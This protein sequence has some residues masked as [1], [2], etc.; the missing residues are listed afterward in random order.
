MPSPQTCRV[1]HQYIENHSRRWAVLVHRPSGPV[2]VTG[3]SASSPRCRDKWSHECLGPYLRTTYVNEMA[4]RQPFSVQ[5]LLD[6][7]SLRI[8]Q[9]CICLN[10]PK[11]VEIHHTIPYHALGQPW[12]VVFA[13]GKLAHDLQIQR[14]LVPE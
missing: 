6:K 1:S 3:N 12:Q 14:S 13:S 7:T 9:R 8:C 10:L 5:M 11:V 4:C 2:P